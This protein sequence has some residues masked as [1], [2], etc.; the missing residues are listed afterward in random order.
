MATQENHQELLRF[1][2]IDEETRAVLRELRPLLEW[3]LPEVLDGFY[4]Y[5]AGFTAPN[6]L[7]RDQAAKDHAKAQQLKHWLLIASGSFDEDYVESVRTVGRV[8]NRIGLEP[9]WYIGGYSYITTELQRCISDHFDAGWPGAWLD[10]GAKRKR[11][12]ALA[13]VNKAALLDMNIAISVYLEENRKDRS[14]ALE[15]LAQQF[16]SSIKEVVDGVA[17]ASGEV[18]STAQG[19]SAVAGQTSEQ[20]ASAAAT[21]EQAME[22]VQ[23]VAAASEELSSSIQEIG[24]RVDESSR[25][26]SDAV[27]KAQHTNAQVEGLSGAARKIGEVI[28]LI[29]DIAEQT[30]LLA[31]NATIEAARAGEAGKGFA[32]VAGEVKALANQTAQATDQISQQVSEI[33]EATASSVAAIQQIVTTIE[34]VSAIA[35]EITSAVGQQSDATREISANIQEAA[36]GTREVS[37]NIGSVTQAVGQAGDASSQMLE[38]SQGL[39]RQ[40]ESLRDAVQQ[41]LERIRAA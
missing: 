19:L 9:A 8:H 5:I 16:E 37:G 25:I 18:L 27:S 32:V 28:S 38:A 35:S 34:S 40:S 24:R 1:N 10:R 13:A 7:F 12:D 29:Q 36:A 23:T 6:G 22:N 17:T 14:H 21:S 15:G 20:A 3:N 30:N 31:L 4:S 26:T 41:F 11:A 39:D 33:Q 2:R